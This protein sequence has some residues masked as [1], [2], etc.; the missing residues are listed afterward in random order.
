MNRTLLACQG[1]K[2]R[3][4][5]SERA[6]ISTLGSSRNSR[7][8]LI[9]GKVVV[10]LTG[11]IFIVNASSAICDDR[12]LPRYTSYPT[13]PHFDP[14]IDAGTYAGWLRAIPAGET[15]SL[16]LHVPFCAAL[17]LYCGCH[18]T[19]VRRYA[20]IAA[21]VDMLEREI[22]LIAEHLG[23]GRQVSHIHWGGGTPTILSAADLL[24]ITGVLRA[25]FDVRPDAEFAIEIDP[26]KLG[27]DEVKTLVAMGVNRASLGVQDFNESVQRA[28]NRIQSYDETARAVAWL[29]DAGISNLNFDLMYGLP[30]QSVDSVLTSVSQALTLTPD[31]IAL[32]GYAHVPWMKRHQA[33]LPEEHLPDAAKRLRQTRAASVAICAAGYVAIG[34][35]HFA[36]PDDSLARARHDGRLRR[37][38][39][40]YTTDGASTLI[41]FGAS[42]IGTLPQGYVQNAATTANYRSAVASNGLATV[43]G[44]ALT[45]DDRLRRDV[46]ERLM[47]DLAVDLEAVAARHGCDPGVFAAEISS[48][49]AKMDED[50]ATRDGYRIVVPE[51]ARPFL[52]HVCAIFDKYL[53]AG[54]RRHSRAL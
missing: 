22:A 54:A 51:E 32:F 35:D 39:Q 28:I 3:G 26:R 33:L 41:G 8:S 23:T 2:T 53:L 18:T 1:T 31:R 11:H 4:Q 48:V 37:N 24:R 9:C 36:K 17:C 12:R 52:R 27:P 42:A 20:P 5:Q 21:Y 19:V 44:L 10:P 50:L 13:A 40:G 49:D 45:A 25:A 34:L 29:R 46:I 38:F 30:H 15:L 47:C 16:Y 7:R 43:R 6:S 14:A